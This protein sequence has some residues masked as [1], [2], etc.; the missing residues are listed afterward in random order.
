MSARWASGALAI[1]HDDGD[2]A[3]FGVRPL[4]TFTKAG[5]LRG[6][7]DDWCGLFAVGGRSMLGDMG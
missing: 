2:V 1:D 4:S 3:G 7:G 5:R 6:R